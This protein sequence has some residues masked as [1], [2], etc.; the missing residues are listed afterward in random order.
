MTRAISLQTMHVQAYVQG[1][2]QSNLYLLAV[3]QN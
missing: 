1:P 2:L 3:F